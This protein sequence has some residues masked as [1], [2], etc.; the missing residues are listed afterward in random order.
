M[1]NSDTEQKSIEVVDILYLIKNTE[2]FEELYELLSPIIR[3]SDEDIVN[4]HII[5]NQQL[6]DFFNEDKVIFDSIMFE[7]QQSIKNVTGK[8]FNILDMFSN[9]EGYIKNIQTRIERE[10]EK[11]NNMERLYYQLDQ[12]KGI[13]CTDFVLERINFTITLDTGNISLM[14]VFN[15]IILEPNI[16]FATKNDYYKI[17]KDFVP[18][19]EWSEY[20]TEQ[21]I[22]LKVNQRKDINQES[23]YI[24]EWT[25]IEKRMKLLNNEY[26]TTNERVLSAIS[27][28]YDNVGNV[29]NY[30]DAPSGA[31]IEIYT[32]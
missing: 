14:E 12:L 19:A 27:E 18:P 29:Q 31:P 26:T 8:R 22:I 4:L 13:T 3:M 15:N 10:S 24:N 20:K 2:S 9:R 17:L 28:D 23:F 5:Y 1:I 30:L 6:V 25:G 21:D 11:S 16:P 7:K 32:I